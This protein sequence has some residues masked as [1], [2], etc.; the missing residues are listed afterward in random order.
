M[1]VPGGDPCKVLVSKEKIL[2]SPVLSQASSVVVERE[3]SSSGVG[4]T[5][6]SAE[7]TG[8]GLVDVLGRMSAKHNANLSSS[9]HITKMH[10]VV[11]VVLACCVTIGVEVTI[12]VVGAGEDS[13]TNIGSL[14]VGKGSRLGATKRRLVVGTTD[15]EL[16]PVGGEWVESIGL[17]LYCISNDYLYY[18]HER[19]RTLTVKSMSEVV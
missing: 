18:H 3:D 1:V 17:D 5:R 10:K 13:E 19:V 11:D 15:V 14:V 8:T 9:T 6:I 16:V 7:N 12:W 4:G 2:I